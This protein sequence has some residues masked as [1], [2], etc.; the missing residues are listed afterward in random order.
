MSTIDISIECTNAS[1]QVKS[2]KIIAGQSHWIHS[3]Q[4]PPYLEGNTFFPHRNSFGTYVRYAHMLQAELMARKYEVLPCPH[5]TF[6]V[7]Q[8]I[9]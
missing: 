2:K 1:L 9:T 4:T 7:W 5:H 8:Y 6:I 3:T